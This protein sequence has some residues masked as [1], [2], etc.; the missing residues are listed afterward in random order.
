MRLKI[1]DRYYRTQVKKISLIFCRVP[2]ITIFYIKEHYGTIPGQ[3]E[4]AR[5]SAAESKSIPTDILGC[6]LQ[7]TCKLRGSFSNFPPSSYGIKFPQKSEIMSHHEEG[8][9][10]FAKFLKSPRYLRH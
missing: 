9:H 7:Q 2:N 8:C 6:K 4:R 10:P 5:L 1:F 3:R